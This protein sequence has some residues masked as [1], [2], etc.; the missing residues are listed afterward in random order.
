L[1]VSGQSSALNLAQADS[2]GLC[3]GWRLVMKRGE[4]N[5]HANAIEETHH[6]DGVVI[7]NYFNSLNTECTVTVVFTLQVRE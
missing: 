6:A 3:L 7:L 2:P 5:S 1:R 4:T